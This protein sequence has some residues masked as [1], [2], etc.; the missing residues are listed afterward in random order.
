MAAWTQAKTFALGGGK[1]MFWF[2]LALFV[3]L[4]GL[5]G[6]LWQFRGWSLFTFDLI[7]VALTT[8][9]LVCLTFI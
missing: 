6:L 4:I 3:I 8:Y 5:V 7:I 1:K 2:E 9:W